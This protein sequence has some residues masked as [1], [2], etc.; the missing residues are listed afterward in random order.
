MKY[1]DPIDMC[2]FQG[3]THD[4]AARRLGW[5]VGTVRSRLSA[6]RLRLRSRLC[7]GDSRPAYRAWPR[8]W[9]AKPERPSREL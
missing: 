9:P 2:H 8:P 3:L 5:P 4:E 6:G 7:A 1:R